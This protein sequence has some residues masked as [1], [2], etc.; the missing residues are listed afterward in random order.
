[1]HAGNDELTISVRERLSDQLEFEISGPVE[2][3]FSRGI[4]SFRRWTFSE[5]LPSS[6]CPMCGGILREVG[7]RTESGRSL[8]LAV[9]VKDH[10]LWVYDSLSGVN[11]PIPVTGFYNE[12]I[13]QQKVQD[14]RVVPEAKRLF[15]E[16]QAHSDAALA[17][18]FSSYN[19]LR[20]KIVLG[21]P[22]IIPMVAGF[23]WFKRV[24]RRFFGN[25]GGTR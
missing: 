21:E 24:K 13:L 1:V 23:S 14:R 8:V 3:D 16:L 25:S 5:W 4:D 17:E 2:T 15:G 20:T 11:H 7:M 18:A 19:R 9:C 22:L 12:L 10:R 6:P